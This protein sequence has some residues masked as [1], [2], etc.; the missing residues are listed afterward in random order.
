MV[1]ESGGAAGEDARTTA[2]G[3]PAVQ[4]VQGV[5]VVDESAGAAGC[6]NAKPTPLMSRRFY[7]DSMILETFPVGPLACN[8]TILGDEETR[9]AIVVDP[10]DDVSRIAKRLS[11]QGRRLGC[12]WPGTRCLPEASAAPICP[13]AISIRFLLRCGGGC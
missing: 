10:G 4:D 7:N 12:C 8:C 1:D 11:E 5:G 3:T 2:G 13:A 9:E 6:S